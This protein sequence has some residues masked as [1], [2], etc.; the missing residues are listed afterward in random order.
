[1]ADQE[2]YFLAAAGKQKGPFSIG[3]LKKLAAAGVLQPTDF[4]WTEGMTEW[5][6]ADQISGLFETPPATPPTIP[7]LL[8]AKCACGRNYRVK[9]DLAGK[10]VK[11][12]ECGARIVVP[13]ENST[14]SPQ[15][16]EQANAFN[17]EPQQGPRPAPPPDLR[18]AAKDLWAALAGAVQQSMKPAVALG[19]PA[20]SCPRC[21]Q[22]TP[23][24]ELPGQVT[25]CS[26]CGSEF[27]APTT[28]LSAANRTTASRKHFWI[29][30]ATCFALLLLAV[31][32][33]QV[34]HKPRGSSP[35]ARVSSDEDHGRL[36]S[37]DEHPPSIRQ[38]LARGRTIW[39]LHDF[40]KR[41]TER[42]DLYVV[43]SGSK[44]DCLV[45]KK[46][47]EGL[48]ASAQFNSSSPVNWWMRQQGGKT[49]IRGDNV[50]ITVTWAVQRADAAGVSLTYQQESVT[51]LTGGNDRVRITEEG[52]LIIRS[53][54]T[55]TAT[56]EFLTTQDETMVLNGKT[57]PDRKTFAR[58]GRAELVR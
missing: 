6:R 5:Q 30:L 29:G 16:A 32:G 1:M 43:L 7:T 3:E 14:P 57:H 8:V 4:V 39:V 56:W 12:P 48:S 52:T 11:C 34:S 31:L 37:F 50:V 33:L 55:R 47:A 49:V 20:I 24:P 27:A 42:T 36:R 46:H 41:Q 44:L 26:H 51:E 10:H 2:W 21:G 15:E 45:H 53:N 17:V 28:L 54:D 22:M 19:S 23:T 35:T 38:D 13:L 40:E 25:I 9:A 18:T 58:E